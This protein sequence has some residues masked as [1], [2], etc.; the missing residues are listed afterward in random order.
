MVTTP[1]GGGGLLKYYLGRDVPLEKYTH[2]YT[3]LCRKM[4]P[5]FIPEPQILSK[6][7]QQFHIIHIIFQKC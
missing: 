5:I 6:F 4:G 2:F 3:K 1:R 7:Y